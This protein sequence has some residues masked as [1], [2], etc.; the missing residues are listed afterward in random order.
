MSIYDK[1]NIEVKYFQPTKCFEDM[2]GIQS[3]LNYLEYIRFE[4]KRLG[5]DKSMDYFLNNERDE[6]Y[7]IHP[8]EILFFEC[9]FNINIPIKYNGNRMF[10]ANLELNNQYLAELKIASDSTNYKQVLPNNILQ[11]IKAN[12]AKVYHGVLKSMNKVPI[13]VM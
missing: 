10:Y 7:F 8:N 6:L 4:Q 11:T 2:K 1:N 3:T 5:Y 9:T 13:K 12:H